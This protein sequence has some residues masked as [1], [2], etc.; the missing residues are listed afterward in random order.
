[1]TVEDLANELFPDEEPEKPKKQSGQAKKAKV[2]AEL[3]QEIVRLRNEEGLKPRQIEEKTGV[4]KEQIY[5]ILQYENER[6][7]K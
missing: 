2:T 7:A 1:M 3:K 4:P 6:R 5:Y